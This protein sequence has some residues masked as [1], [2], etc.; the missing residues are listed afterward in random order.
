MKYPINNHSLSTAIKISKYISIVLLFTAVI[1]KLYHPPVSWFQDLGR[2]LKLGEIIINTRSVP[3]I[4]LFTYTNENFPFINHHWLSEVFF[5]LI[6]TTTGDIGLGLLKIT[7]LALSIYFALKSSVSKTIS[8]S[9]LASAAFMIPIFMERTHIR[10]E[11]F[12]MFL[13]S[14][15]LL[16]LS[17]PITKRGVV[18][19]VIIQLLWVN[20]HIYFAIGLLTIIAYTLNKYRQ[21]SFKLMVRV[22]I[23]CIFVS[24]INPNGLQGLLLPLQIFKEYGYSIIENQSP[25][26]LDNIFNKPNITFFKVSLIATLISILITIK[27]KRIYQALVITLV[28]ILALKQVR[29]FPLYALAF[30]SFIPSIL[31]SIK[32]QTSP[33][34]KKSLSLIVASLTIILLLSQIYNRFP[35]NQADRINSLPFSLSQDQN[36][37][38][39]FKFFNDK[40]IEGPIFN[41]FDV[42][43]LSIYHLYPQH[44]LFVDN[45]PEAFPKEFFQQT[46]IPMQEDQ[47]LFDQKLAEYKFQSIIFSHNDITPWGVTFMKNIANHPQFKLVYLDA[48][49]MILVDVDQYPHIPII[50]QDNATNYI[51]TLAKQS[52]PNQLARLKRIT[53]IFKFTSTSNYLN[54]KLLLSD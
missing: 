12:S 41:N 19:I 10:P 51:S 8:V 6:H 3:A 29:N 13:F 17:K 53:E 11:I 20:L 40:G 35:H 5:Y 36:I 18:I 4:N 42:A 28:T 25:F 39:S 31:S 16:I 22:S 23:A 54:Q 43:G 52:T 47:G 50:D 33:Y 46:Y 45:R 24:L 26:F 32:L 38:S 30:I 2:H 49:I 7:L 44:K 1:I 14:L 34:I 37:H 48:N 15:L 27:S 21:R 9:S